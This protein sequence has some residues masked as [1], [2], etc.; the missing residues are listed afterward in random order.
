MSYSCSPYGTH[1]KFTSAIKSDM[2]LASLV[3]VPTYCVYGVSQKKRKI[4][5][6]N[7]ILNVTFLLTHTVLYYMQVQL[8][9]FPL[10]V[11]VLCINQLVDRK[12]VTLS[13]VD[14]MSSILSQTTAVGHT[15]CTYTHAQR[16]VERGLDATQSQS[17]WITAQSSLLVSFATSS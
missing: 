15:V 16:L 2:F 9:L 8:L 1:C 12:H 4:T 3:H 6:E 14:A 7:Y 11:S 10:A 5:R 17:L 13:F